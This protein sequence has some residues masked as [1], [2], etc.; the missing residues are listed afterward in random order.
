[1]EINPLETKS[2]NKHKEVKRGFSG[3]FSPKGI[4]V[5]YGKDKLSSDT[6]I[7]NQTASQ[8]ISNKDINIEA[9]DKIK[10]KSVDIY[11]K[12]DVNISGDNGVEIS[13]ANNSYDNTTKQ[14]SSRIGA[15]VGI[16]SAIV[17][18]V[19]NIKDIKNLTDFSGDSYDIVNKASKVV[20][21]IKDG[22]KATIAIA[23]TSYKGSTDAGYDNLKI[24]NNVFTASISYNK[25]ESKSSVHNES[26]EKSLIEAG[27][28]MN[29]KSK[30]GSISISGADVKVGND[31]SLTAKKDID[32]KAAE[33]K[34]TS[35]SSSSQTGVS[36]SVNLEEGR[37]A[38]LSISKA[39]AK[40][41]GNGTSYVNST[42]NVG[43][44]LKTNSENLTL[45]GANVEADKVDIKAKNVVIESKQD[46]SENKDSTY[47]GGFSIDL[48]NPSNF[49]VNVNGSK[50]NGEKECVNKQT[51]LIAK[52]GGKIDTENLTNIG[53]IIGSESETNKLKVSANKVVVKDLEDKNKY[54]NIGGGVSFGTNVP[55]VSVKYDKV[56]KEQINRATALNTDFEVAGQKV[57]AEDLGF[58]TNKD[59]AQEVTKDEERHLDA[60]LHTD[61]LGK[62]KQEELKKA[63]GIV[64][65]LTT[66]LGN[67]GKTEGDFL[68]RYKQLS[69]VRA[70]GDQVEKNPE[71]LSILD[72]KAIKNEKIDD[73]VQK[74]QVSVMN[75]LLNDALRAKGYAGPDIKMVLTDV[76]DP[77]GPFYTDTLT[78]VVVFDRKML[79]SANRD[80][81]LNALGHEF[82]HYSKE[83]NKTGTQT[84]ANYSGDK[85]EDRTKAMV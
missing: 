21:A 16:N 54:E 30:D 29:I 33:E 53:A 71:F 46:K 63:G 26:V 38:D 17:N 65:D 74:E 72:K 4:S 66:A 41:K 23:D 5:S 28:N 77:N 51:S 13:T 47:G 39:G 44:K 19:E 50:G 61:L 2:Y 1:V 68:E 58:N 70:I 49:S 42:I 31:L 76:K 27:R 10:A 3:S 57:K 36:L 56:D 62:D 73:D 37:L 48:V 79:A 83:D 64:S 24:M 59:K 25:S 69:M 18:T 34:F 80:E 22:A 32:I 7:L 55:N 14:S 67:K 60:E 9:T 12:N 82:G 35:S 15:S 6:D 20:G 52:N 45:S 85:L 84:I 81:I 43:G 11:A 40:G 78:N 75:K 8:I